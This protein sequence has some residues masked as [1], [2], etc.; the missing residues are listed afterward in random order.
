MYIHVRV[1][2][3]NSSSMTGCHLRRLELHVDIPNHKHKHIMFCDFSASFVD[4]KCD[5][6]TRDL[7]L[8]L[9]GDIFTSSAVTL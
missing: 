6:L 4:A 7:V 8:P 2:L 5:D 3:N 1:H 9:T